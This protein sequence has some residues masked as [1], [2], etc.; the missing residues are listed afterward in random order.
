MPSS[1]ASSRGRGSACTSSRNTTLPSAR[2]ARN[3]RKVARSLSSGAD[4]SASGCPAA[5]AIPRASVLLPVPAGPVSSVCGKRLPRARTPSAVSRKR[6]T[7]S[8]WPTSPAK[9][10]ARPRAP[11]PHFGRRHLFRRSGREAEAPVLAAVAH[12]ARVS[13]PPRR[14]HLRGDRRER[15]EALVGARGRA[16]R[17]ARRRAEGLDGR[18]GRESERSRAPLTCSGPSTGRP[19]E[20]TKR[21]TSTVAPSIASSPAWTRPWHL[22]H[23]VMRFSTRVR[24]PCERNSMWWTISDQRE[25][26]ERHRYPSRRSTRRRMRGGVLTSRAR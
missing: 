17:G 25:R 14:V 18:R 22:E 21:A 2:P 3:R 1:S 5:T 9:A 20:S 8:S 4:T 24:P 12:Q 15:H 10:S 16:R 11:A 26:H 23:A 19:A 13:A 7:R 6:R